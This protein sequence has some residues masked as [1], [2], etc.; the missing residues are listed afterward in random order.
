MLCLTR[1]LVSVLHYLASNLYGRLVHRGVETKA[2]YRGSTILCGAR[3]ARVSLAMSLSNVFCETSKFHGYQEVRCRGVGFLSLLLGLKGGF[4]GVLARRFR[5]SIRTIRANISSYLRSYDFQHVRA[6]GALYPYGSHVR[7][8][9]TNVYGT[10]RGLHPL[11]RLLSD[12]AIVFLVRRGSNLLPIP[13]VCFV[14]RAILFGLGGY[15][16]FFSSGSLNGFRSFLTTC[17]YVAPLVSSASPS[18]VLDGSFL[19]YV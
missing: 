16:G 12:G 11:T 7:N 14:F 3:Y 1:S 9:E 13:S 6:G 2:N 10:I 4:G 17:L 15:Q 18:P 19:R 5:Y 8:G